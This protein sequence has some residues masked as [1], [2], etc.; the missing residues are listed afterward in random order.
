MF[1]EVTAADGME[2]FMVHLDENNEPIRIYGYADFFQRINNLGYELD[3]ES[4][5]KEVYTAKN[6]EFKSKN[7]LFVDFTG[8]IKYAWKYLRKFVADEDFE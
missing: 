4:A 1:N 7:P 2:E 5:E 6:W 8:D 3:G